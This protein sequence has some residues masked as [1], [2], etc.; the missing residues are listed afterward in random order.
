M[1][2]AAPHSASF[3][4]T[5]PIEEQHAPQGSALRGRLGRMAPYLV[6]FAVMAWL[7]VLTGRFDYDKTAGSLGPD[8]WPRLILALGAAV[9]LFEVVRIALFGGRDAQAEEPAAA[10][11]TALAVEDI[12]DDEPHQGVAKLAHAAP[13]LAWL[14]AYILVLDTLGFFLATLVFLLGFA[15]IAGYRRPVPLVLV[16]LGLTVGFMVMF[17]RVIYVSLP[18]GIEPFA[19]VSLLM[20]KLLGVS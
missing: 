3:P 8:A 20:M 9:S 16:S 10:P 14:V 11:D 6:I 12:P 15:A 18:I 17:M 13:A 2:G 19:Q 4:V 5:T 7:F 1:Q